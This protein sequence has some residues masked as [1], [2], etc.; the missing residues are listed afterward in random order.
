MDPVEVREL[1]R[2][3]VGRLSV[4]FPLRPVVFADLLV[5]LCHDHAEISGM[6]EWKRTLSRGISIARLDQRHGLVRQAGNEFQLAVPRPNDLQKLN[7][8]LRYKDGS[9]LDIRFG[10]DIFRILTPAN[11]GIA[12]ERVEAVRSLLHKRRRIVNVMPWGFVVLGI[13]LGAP[14]F[15][16]NRY[17]R[18]TVRRTPIDP[19]FTITTPGLW[20]VA[21]GGGAIMVAALLNSTHTRRRVLP[22]TN[23]TLEAVSYLR[24]G[25]EDLRRYLTGIAA[26]ATAFIIGLLVHRH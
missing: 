10:E 11:G 21:L 7:L 9:E 5:R 17:H 3:D 23:R 12:R 15:I 4:N 13:I 25:L 16:L 24:F 22:K 1:G 6:L 20:L 26:T 19:S 2:H 18:T 8:L 14:P